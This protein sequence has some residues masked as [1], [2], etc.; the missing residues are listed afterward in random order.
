MV[1][2]FRVQVEGFNIFSFNETDTG[3]SDGNI[4]TELEF[5][6]EG[7]REG[8]TEQ[9]VVTSGVL[10]SELSTGVIT[11]DLGTG[12]VGEESEGVSITSVINLG[13]FDLVL[14]S[15]DEIDIDELG[16]TVNTDNDF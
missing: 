11:D 14:K 8:L 16:N 9:V 4:E 15:L 10:G 1:S 6:D 13:V 7:I 2:D 3:P 5:G 12:S